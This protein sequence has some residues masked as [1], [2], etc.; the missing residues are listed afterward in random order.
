MKSRILIVVVALAL[1]SCA[2]K[3][4]ATPAA[5]TENIPVKTAAL[6]AELAEGQNLY[7]N[8]CGKCHKLYEPKKYTQEEWK[9]ILVRM[10]KK[11][12]LDDTQIASVSNYITSQL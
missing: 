5:V 4:P 9:P 8:N 1:F 11:A 10:Q 7:D 3:T 12:H 2:T 6:S